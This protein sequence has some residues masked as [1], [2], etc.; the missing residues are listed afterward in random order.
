M[1]TQFHFMDKSLLAKPIAKMSFAERELLKVRASQA[2][3]SI[4]GSGLNDEIVALQILENRGVI[5]AG[6]VERAID[7]I[8][9][10]DKPVRTNSVFARK[11]QGRSVD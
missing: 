2:A 10:E 6:S 9:A 4:A 11:G 1:S 5:P 3:E 7:S 8:P